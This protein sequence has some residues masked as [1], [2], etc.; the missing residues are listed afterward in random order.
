MT[1]SPKF[2]Q[3]MSSVEGKIKSSSIVNC[4]LALVIRFASKYDS[5]IQSFVFQFLVLFFFNYKK[6]ICI[7]KVV[8]SRDKYSKT[9]KIIL[10]FFAARYH[11]LYGPVTARGPKLGTTDLH[12]YTQDT[13]T[14]MNTHKIQGLT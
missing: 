5:H 3:Q 4:F 7:W 10:N 1:A 8:Q 2:S 9:N 13:I 11:L 12:E 6:S 14:Y